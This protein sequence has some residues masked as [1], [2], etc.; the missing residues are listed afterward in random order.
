MFVHFLYL[1]LLTLQ[2][3]VLWKT[4][5]PPAPF[6]SD[7]KFFTII[8]RNDETVPHYMLFKFNPNYKYVKM[9]TQKAKFLGVSISFG[10]CIKRLIY[11]EIAV[12]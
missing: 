12:A 6:V 3:K 2:N 8:V 10:K 11:T 4:G 9:G 5:C 1:F 7:D